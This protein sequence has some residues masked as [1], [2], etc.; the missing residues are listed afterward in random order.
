MTRASAVVV[1]SDS[2]RVDLDWILPLIDEIIVMGG[3]VEVFDFTPMDRNDR[4]SYGMRSLHHVLGHWPRRYADLEPIPSVMARFL[5][6]LRA[7]A[8]VVAQIG[9]LYFSPKSP[10]ERIVSLSKWRKRARARAL[11]H[12]FVNCT[13][14]FVGLRAEDWADGTGEA[15]LI[16]VARAHGVPVIGFPPVVDHEIP[17]RRLMTCDIALANTTQQAAAWEKV[18]DARVLAVGPPAFTKRWQ[19]R[20]EAVQ[21]AL[22]G[23]FD[24]PANAKLALVILKNDNSIVWTD[25]D[26][27]K[28][29][30]EML[31]AL[32]D[33]GMH[34]LIKRHPRQSPEALLRLLDPVDSTRY[35]LVDGPLAYWAQRADLVVSLFSGGILDCLAVGRVAILY[36]PMTASYM[37]KVRSGEVTD[38]YVRR[39]GDGTPITKYRDFCF[40]VTDPVFNLPL[41]A[42]T[43]SR[44]AAFRAHYPVAENCAAIHALIAC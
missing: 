11:E 19:A 44:L 13:G 18:S 36:W 4:S 15:E 6:R 39:D 42:D 20:I 33:A 1:I 26:F 8:G 3:S 31:A 5:D 35:T 21:H 16:E 28:T 41:R 10:L 2:S 30:S 9:A 40:E 23:N 34:L 14:L 12:L 38:V 27:H 17:H 29:A 32:L 37:K 25:L 7:K 24:A 22:L 43:A